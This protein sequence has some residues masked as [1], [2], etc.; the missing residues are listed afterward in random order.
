MI[1]CIIFESLTKATQNE[2]TS[3]EPWNNSYHHRSDH[4]QSCRLERNP[5]KYQAGYKF[6]TCCFWIAGS[7]F[8]EQVFRLRYSFHNN[9]QIPEPPGFFCFTGLDEQ[10]AINFDID[11]K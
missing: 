1:F 9:I 7:Y 10:N 2:R 3:Q 8:L 5:D 4:S 6:N 11:I